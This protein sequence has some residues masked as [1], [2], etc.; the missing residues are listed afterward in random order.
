MCTSGTRLCTMQEALLRL[1]MESRLLTHFL[2]VAERRSIT[3]AA[4]ALHIS[5]PALTHSVHRLEKLIGARLFE[6][7]PTGVALTRP[8]EIL[9]RRV[10]LMDLEYRHALAEIQMLEKGLSGTLRIGAGPVWV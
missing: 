6:R 4:E 2:A 1:K 5:Q 8:G 9:V 10:K 3:G 7:M